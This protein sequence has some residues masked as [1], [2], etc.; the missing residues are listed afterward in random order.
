M[1]G[2]SH[3]DLDPEDPPRRSR[4]G[5]FLHSSP[6]PDEP[7]Q[8]KLRHLI[9]ESCI[10]LA[11]SPR[12]LLEQATGPHVWTILIWRGGPDV[13]RT[14]LPLQ[15]VFGPSENVFRKW[16]IRAAMR[17]GCDKRRNVATAW[18]SA[19]KALKPLR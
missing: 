9:A 14:Q 5:R 1:R 6:A 4:T 15:I 13:T 3:R 11:T 17:C 10:I 7:E 8:V 2:W 12:N 19:C 18:P 16:K